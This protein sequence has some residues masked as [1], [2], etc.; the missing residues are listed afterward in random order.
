MRK[1]SFGRYL[2]FAFLIGMAVF[3]VA[4][5]LLVHQ[6][7]QCV[8]A[9][10]T[11]DGSKEDNKES[12]VVIVGKTIGAQIICTVRVLDKHNGFFAAL[13]GLAVALFT[14]TLWRSTDK[15]WDASREQSEDMKASISEA[16]RAANAMENVA[17]GIQT[18]V[19]TNQIFLA[20]QRQFW[21]QQMRAYISVDVG[22]Y[23][24]QNR[25]R[26]LRFD[27]K[28]N[29]VNA[30]L[31]PASD[32]LILSRLEIKDTAIPADFDFSLQDA[33]NHM[34][35]VTTVFPRQ[36]LFH[37]AVFRR[38]ATIHEMRELLRGTQIFHLWGEVRYCDIFNEPHRTNFSFLIFVP[39]NKRGMPIWHRTEN[40]NDAT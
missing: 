11:S 15:L 4:E 16:A 22:G 12:K 17:D 32:V 10:T 1:L 2:I 8:A 14:F 20:Q 35:S 27:F 23:N 25:R 5:N 30:G 7:Q 19:A 40:H 21:A 31:T 33:P 36:G 6:F 39:T 9:R 13:A 3:V 37:A 24:R 28:P 34:R 26:R 18:S 38:D 29:L